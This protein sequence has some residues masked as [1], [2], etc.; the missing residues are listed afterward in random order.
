[1]AVLTDESVTT[2]E[3]ESRDLGF[4][5]VVARERKRLLNRDGSFNVRRSGLGFWQS[6]SLYH[7]LLTMSWRKFLTLI[8]LAYVAV[9]G[10]FAV[11]YSMCG[12]GALDGDG[13]GNGTFAQAFFFSVQTFGTIGYG[14]EY[15]V[16]TAA[17]VLVAVES[18]FG[19]LGFALATGI[20]FARFSR[21]LAQI[22]FSRRAVIAPYGDKR[23]FMFRIAN[24]RS[25]ELIET[26]ARIVLSR[27]VTINGTATRRFSTLKLERA[28]VAFLPLSWTI[29][30]PIDEDSPLWGMNEEDY[31]SYG[32]EFLVLLTA[33]DET[34][35]QTVHAR[36]SYSFDEIE[37]NARFSDIFG[38]SQ[39]AATLTVD[40]SRIDTIEAVPN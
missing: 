23:A 11:A 24:V 20:M 7:T 19:L 22:K 35:S 28:K 2:P 12:P 25:N 6:S 33:I 26:E 29:V 32:V 30:H 4:G 38:R 8:V 1:M 18:L 21:P 36:M 15:P 34:F 13:A 3:G 14:H 17:N 31:A 16:S 5:S 9:N 39:D 10:L 27:F 37:W 40:I